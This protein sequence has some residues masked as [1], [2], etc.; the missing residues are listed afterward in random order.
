MSHDDF[1][2]ARD[3]TN[4]LRSSFRCG[5]TFASSSVGPC[6]HSQLSSRKSDIEIHKNDPMNVK[7]PRSVSYLSG[8][9]SHAFHPSSVTKST[10]DSSKIPV[11]HVET[12]VPDPTSALHRENQTKHNTITENEVEDMAKDTSVSTT[13]TSEEPKELGNDNSTLTACSIKEGSSIDPCVET[14]DI[15]EAQL[16]AMSEGE[17]DQTFYSS[18]NAD[19][20][21]SLNV[22]SAT[23]K[24]FRTLMFPL[25]L[26]LKPGKY[27]NK[28]SQMEFVQRKIKREREGFGPCARQITKEYKA[29]L[30]NK[31]EQINLFNSIL[32][33]NKF[34]NYACFYCTKKGHVAKSCPTKLSDERLYAQAGSTT[35]KHGDEATRARIRKNKE[36]VKCF[37]C[38]GTGHFAN[39]CPQNDT[40]TTQKQEKE[41]SSAI[42]ITTEMVTRM[43]QRL[44]RR[45]E[46]S[47]ISGLPS[48]RKRKASGGVS[49]R[50][51]GGVTV[52]NGLGV[53][54]GVG[55]YY[56][57]AGDVVDF[58]TWLGISLETTM[59][60]T[61]DLDEEMF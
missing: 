49:R 34:R 15:T 60:S 46:E 28:P 54:L 10:L 41:T 39:V 16:D 55:L 5:S 23:S 3:I 29:M 12:Y 52:C 45:K 38:H 31:I 19:N 33:S 42:P 36:T 47:S 9:S 59:M 17:V 13:C 48:R 1:S 44:R 30:R 4:S 32:S 22:Q 8:T 37:K 2:Y 18:F 43:D 11:I 35:F 20:L 51:E 21:V 24:S 14:T 53:G 40:K 50:D 57:C 27:R 26:S 56:E 25:L 61:M 6:F 58:R 7:H